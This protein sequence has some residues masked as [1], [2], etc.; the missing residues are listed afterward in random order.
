MVKPG[1]QDVGVGQ[2]PDFAGSEPRDNPLAFGLWRLADN[3]GRAYATSLENACDV[4]RV[5][6]ASAEKQPRPAITGQTDNLVH[7]RHIVIVRINGGLQFAFDVF[8][9]ALVDAV[10]RQLVRRQL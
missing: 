5:S 7:D 6:N 1:R 10:N 9:A 4:V 8:A 2:R 3:T